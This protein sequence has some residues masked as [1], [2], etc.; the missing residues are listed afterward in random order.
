MRKIFFV[1][2]MTSLLSGLVLNKWTVPASAEPR[3]GGVL[4]LSQRTGQ[5]SFGIP[6]NVRGKAR[7]IIAWCCDRMVQRGEEP[8]TYEG[9]LAESFELSP[10]KLS[11]TFHLRQ[12]VKFHDGTKFNAQ[13]VKWNW[14]KVLA[15]KDV[16]GVFKKVTSFDILDDYTIR[17][18][19][20][21]W[22]ALIL[23]DFRHEASSVI[24]PTYYEKY[25]EEWCNT[26]PIGAG[27]WVLKQYVPRLKYVFERNPDYWNK[28]YPYI[29][30]LELHIIADPMTAMAS[31]LRGE[32]DGLDEVDMVL[33]KNLT[34]KGYKTNPLITGGNYCLYGNSTSP[35][36]AWSDIRMRQALEYAINKER[37]A[38]SLGQG[39]MEPSYEV[40]RG[41]HATGDPGT[42]PRKYDPGKAKQLMIEAGYKN[43]L[44]VKITV[45]DKFYGDYIVAVQSDLKKV[46]IDVEILKM[47]GP[48]YQEV[49]FQPCKGNELRWGRARGHSGNGI[50]IYGDSDFASDCINFPAVKRPEGFDALLDQ[51]MVEVDLA[52]RASIIVKMEKLMYDDVFLIP[53]WNVPDIEFRTPDLKWDPSIR[54]HLEYSSEDR[55]LHFEI[56]WLDR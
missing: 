46:G 6:L 5:A 10:D 39:F 52:K 37:I 13:A 9:V 27:P 30:T 53:L 18:N 21:S 3:F 44:K 12:G 8:G 20:T 41:A 31:F 34:D 51:A 48:I 45:L 54:K 11:Y 1:A 15:V 4:K 47:P 14:D 25:G 24:S 19:L 33:A 55:Q 32:V 40:L 38:E 23:E 28:P 16:R 50:L 42:T 49:R 7:D 35:D 29:D 2:L 22:D 43:G 17:A 56:G 26:H 36:S